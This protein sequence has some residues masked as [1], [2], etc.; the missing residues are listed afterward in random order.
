MPFLHLLLLIA[1][2]NKCCNCLVCLAACIKSL[3]AV[4]LSP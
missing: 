2:I 4:F 1:I 3:F